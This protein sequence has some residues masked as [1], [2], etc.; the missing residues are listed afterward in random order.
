MADDVLSVV[1]MLCCAGLG[2]AVRCV[3]DPYSILA[4]TYVLSTSIGFLDR[5]S[6]DRVEKG[7]TKADSL[8]CLGV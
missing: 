5:P 2:W 6:Q 7:G 4:S 3:G 8:R 1:A